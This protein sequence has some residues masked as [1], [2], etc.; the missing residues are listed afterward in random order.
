LVETLG[1]LV[2][3]VVAA[4][5]R[6]ARLGWVTLVQRYLA[7]SV[8]RLRQIWVDGGEEAQWLCDGVRG[9]QQTHKRALAVVEHTGN[10]WHVVKHR[11]KVERTFGWVGND[12]R[13]SRDDEVLTARSE[14]M[15]QISRSRLLLK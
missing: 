6:E 4:A 9:L 12:R 7:S 13:H 15:M 2:A 1:L 10:G 14:A 8:P 5:Q 11:G 3:V